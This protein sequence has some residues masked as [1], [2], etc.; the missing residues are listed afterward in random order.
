MK[1]LGTLLLLSA[2]LFGTNSC[3]VLNEAAS[4]MMET[5]STSTAPKLTNDE[6]IRG[7][8]EALTVGIK[9]S[10]DITSATDGFLS[11]TEIRLPFPPDALKVKEKALEWGL[12]NQVQNFE[13]TLNRAAE[14]AATEALPI[15]IDAITNMSVQDGFALLNGGQGAATD[16]LK[17]NTS[18][19]LYAAFLPKVEE[20]IAQVK[21][22]EYWNPIAT[23]Y[24]TAMTFTGG[25]K[26]NP[27][28]SDY[29]THRAI[30]GLFV[31]VE[32]EENKIRA[33]PAARVSDI[34]Q[35][36]FGS[37]QP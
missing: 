25:D 1:K 19:A 32:K 37:V 9:N 36:V 16:F 7:L 8:K 21:L 6:V 3:D 18:E 28:L 10:V 4:V 35:K 11:N 2:T 12:D 27:D 31:M 14:N 22:T 24:N 17:R 20:S 5:G 13:T 15:F 33:N 30:D 34:L 26:V 23:K 29:V